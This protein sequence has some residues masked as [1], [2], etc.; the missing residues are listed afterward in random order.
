MGMFYLLVIARTD[1]NSGKCWIGT[2]AHRLAGHREHRTLC[3]GDLGMER[4]QFSTLGGTGRRRTELRPSHPQSLTAGGGESSAPRLSLD[5][6]KDEAACSTQTGMDWGRSRLA[7]G[8][9]LQPVFELNWRDIRG[10]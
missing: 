1:R 2:K 3:L 5:P 8:E 9:K 4:L 6:E 10:P 7:Q